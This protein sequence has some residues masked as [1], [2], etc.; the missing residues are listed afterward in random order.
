MSAVL[1]TPQKTVQTTPDKL[2]P[3]E[4]L[5]RSQI[6]TR[7]K[8]I[9]ETDLKPLLEPEHNGK[10]LSINIFSGAYQIHETLG[11]VT[12]YESSLPDSAGTI[13]PRFLM[14]IG[15]TTAFKRG[16]RWRRTDD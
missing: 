13:P 7:G 15:Y 4:P 2:P 16:G 3:L 9:Y 10:F 8:A 6:I 1:N 12:V 11:D 14:R 5:T